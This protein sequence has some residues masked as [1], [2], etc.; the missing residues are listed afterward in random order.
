MR[1]KLV[2]NRGLL[3]VLAAA[4]LAALGGAA[5]AA[6]EG[7]HWQVESRSVPGLLA[8]GAKEAEIRALAINLGDTDATGP[9][10]ITDRLP[11]G[12][13]ATGISAR[14]GDSTQPVATFS[15][16]PLPDLSCTYHESELQTLARKTIPPYQ[17]L[18]VIV[19]V[20]VEAG[21]TSG[22]ENEVKVEGG[23]APSASLR[24]AIAVSSAPVPFGVENYALRPENED[25]SPATQAGEHPFQLTTTLNFNQTFIPAASSFEPS[26]PGLPA[27][28]KD[29]T[30]N[31]PPG[32]LGNAS[33]V[34]Q[35]TTGDFTEKVEAGQG[36][37]NACAADTAVGVASVTYFSNY[38][39]L[40]TKAVPVFNLVPVPGE[41][42]RF[43]F[44]VSNVPVFLDT[45]IRTGGDYGV[46][47]SV[48]NA[49]TAVQVLGSDVVI[50]GVPGDPR[51]DNSRGWECVDG[52]FFEAAQGGFLHPC[53]ALG[54]PQPK[55]FLTLPTLCG[56][57]PETTMNGDAWPTTVEH[58]G[59]VDERRT[60]GASALLAPMTGCEKLEFEPSIEAQPDQHAAS[61]PSG[62]KVTVKLP[63]EGTLSGKGLAEATVEGATVALPEGLLASPGAA[64]GLLACSATGGAGFNGSLEGEQLENDH[65]TPDAV[66]CPDASKI[67]TVRIKTPVL[68]DQLTG[69]VYLAAQNTNPFASPLVLYV[70]AE[71]PVSGVRVKLAGEVQVNP[72]TGQL[73]SV[74]RNTPPAPFD[75]LELHLFDGPRAS[76]STPPYCGTYTTTSAFTPWS[77]SGPTQGTV[78]PSSNFDIVSGPAGG[79]C[80]GNPLGFAPGFRAGS[81]NNQAGSFTPFTVTIDRPDGDQ[82][83]RGLTMHL[84]PGIAAM[85][86]SVTPC[87]EPQAAQGTCGV[88]SLIGHT[89]TSSG[90]G[91]APVSLPGQVYLTGPYKGAPFGLTVVTPA[92]AGPFNLGNVVVRSTINVDRN[93]AAVSIASDPFPTIL[94]G[95]PV[96]LKQINVTVD[97]G[98]F[99]FN[100]TS[101]A[102]MAITATLGGAEGASRALS[103]PFQAANCASLPFSPKLT[104]V[105]QGNASKANGASL[106]VR[107][108]S[109]PGQANIGKTKL[110]LPLALPSRLT[111]IQKA[112][113]DKVFE[114][115][116]AACPEGSNIGTATVH[117]PVLRSVLRGPA[118]LVSHGNAAFPDVEFVLQGEGITL[119]LDG[120]TDIKKGITTST[121]NTLPDAPVTTFEAV[122]PEGPHSALTSNVAA[123]KRFNLCGTKLVMP[124]TITG[125]NGAVI[126]QRTKVAVTGC[127]AVKG[128]R[129]T[130]AA[131]LARA[132]KA[133]RKR[134]HH[135]AKR[136]SACEAKARRRFASP[137]AKKRTKSRSSAA[138]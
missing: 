129:A 23:N 120:Q 11:K 67:G 90:L 75:E 71:N 53:Q 126:Q 56:G 87:P 33:A 106:T 82:A 89:T 62:L 103:T 30:F 123:S 91:G 68:P 43:G 21:A 99:Q 70:I 44:E 100:P 42:A 16:L 59:E 48:K 72:A 94:K 5:P 15:C 13:V 36:N 121:F 102:P 52:G 131:R 46:V 124:T 74:F 133:C 49:S 64:N 50:W 86:S 51:H 95:V 25:G 31:L 61:T 29:L 26:H 104:A 84:P 17:R 45:S 63:Q 35:C 125:Q 80:P 122:L 127:S 96:Q 115:N 135:S 110:A 10:T 9:I 14:E 37:L 130:R 81:T 22:E 2:G 107:V 7:P 69:F 105:T 116:P 27:L 138:R 78:S 24:Q 77:G 58:N 97:R 34:A 41:P 98:G 55:A 119:V 57:Q 66:S 85:L 6:A 128:F 47:V 73:T 8:P 79:P 111:T 4:A 32:L 39:R 54:Q 19:T 134:F 114:A 101:C 112:C 132:L 117:T 18:E 3:G 136:R 76:N 38:L 28:P 60:L 40:Q 20:R 1:H 137:H 83:V 118:Y 109:S 92:V 93:T 108:S 12:L 65:F 113:L 88:Q